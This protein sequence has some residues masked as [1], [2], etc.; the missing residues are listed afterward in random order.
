MK[1]VILD[2]KIGGK[3]GKLVDKE[4]KVVTLLDREVLVVVYQ[5]DSGIQKCL[6]SFCD[7]S[8]TFLKRNNTQLRGEIFKL[9]EEIKKL[10]EK[11]E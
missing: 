5:Y 11:K 9:Q 6:C 4:E 2:K 8:K 7:S 3:H 1:S 10:K